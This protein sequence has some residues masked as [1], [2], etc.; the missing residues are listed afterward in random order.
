MNVTLLAGFAR[1]VVG[2]SL[3]GSVAWQVSD[4]I[5]DG[6]FRPSEYFAYFSIVSAIAA[7]VILIASGVQ[8]LRRTP[9]PPVMAI[10]RLTAAASMIVVAVVYHA[11]IGDAAVNPLDIGYEWPA[12]PNLVIHT[13][14]PIAIAL[15]Y[16][17]S[18]H[19][20]PLRLR[21]AFWVAVFPL[22]WLAFSVVRGLNDGWWPYW[23]IDPN[24][25]GGVGG[26]LAYVLA[27]A[28][29]FVALGLTLIALNLGVRRLVRRVAARQSSET[30][31]PA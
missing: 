5:V 19:G 22:V 12:V 31:V 27:I 15:D 25:E 8:R 26:M 11:L 2:L 6:F 28:S 3:A 9:E 30:Q 29:F 20:R 21:Q 18:T 1:V 10:L 4:R 24:G 23:F 16:L 14:A 13:W 17:L 7:A